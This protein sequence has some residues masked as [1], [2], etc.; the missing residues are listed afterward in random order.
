MPLLKR[1]I[2]LLFWV[3][4]A[5]CLLLLVTLSSFRWQELNQYYRDRQTALVQQWYRNFSAILEQQEGI[6]TLMGE[7]L[8]LLEQPQQVH[9]RLDAIMASNP[10]MFSGFALISPQV[11]VLHTSTNLQSNNPPNLLRLPQTQDSFLYALEAE[12][13]VLG[14]TYLA[15]RLVIPA[16][17][18]IRAQNGE[19]LGVMT[20]AL[21][22]GS[23]DG[24]FGRNETSGDFNRI[25]IIRSRDRFIQYST[26]QPAQ[27][28][29]F[30]TPIPADEYQQFVQAVGVS[31]ELAAGQVLPF[32]RIAADDRGA[33]L[34]MAMYNP[35]YEFW[36][37]SEM[38]AAYLWQEFLR[39]FSGYFLVFIAFLTA[40]FY[41]FR[42]IYRVELEK[43]K[44][45]DYQANHDVLT[46]LPNRNYLL[47]IF[48]SWQENKSDF[49][50]VF[51]DLDN[52]KGVNDGFGHKIGDDLL[53]EF[54]RRLK[55]VVPATSLL[56]RYGGDEFLMLLD[57]NQDALAETSLTSAIF[58]ACENIQI[59]N[60]VFSP[61]VS[62]G[63]AH[64][65]E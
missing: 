57:T 1:N 53:V 40:M 38:T 5:A 47:K 23:D 39:I 3:L 63:I 37:V 45:L 6:I 60:L 2:W 29:F 20:G 64:Y 48:S 32:R 58:S 10:E 16:R 46:D 4:A 28:D 30:R 59:R 50:L 49:S 18:A 61:G 34:G 17:K 13:M 65:P 41:L 7:D 14:R 24:L 36:L 33:L 19:V 9:I 44:V 15:P 55:Q 25:T 51:I 54:S 52:F 12:K 62:L 35:R 22:F 11:D 8:L 42:N 56:L 43:H 26:Y 31:T 27:Q 21:K